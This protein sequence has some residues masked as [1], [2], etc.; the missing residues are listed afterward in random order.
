[1]GI[2]I[3]RIIHNMCIFVEKH[4]SQG[5]RSEY[6]YKATPGGFNIALEIKD[7]RLNKAKMINQKICMSLLLSAVYH[8]VLKP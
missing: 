6:C 7:Q 2:Q 1:M 3:R 5:I 4:S 8:Q